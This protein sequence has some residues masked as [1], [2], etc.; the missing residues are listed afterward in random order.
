MRSA[1]TSSGLVPTI[2]LHADAQCDH[3]DANG[4][5]DRRKRVWH[6]LAVVQVGVG[7][8][9]GRRA[10]KEDGK[11]VHEVHREDATQ[12]CFSTLHLNTTSGRLTVL[13]G[14]RPRTRSKVALWAEA[15]PCVLAEAPE[16]LTL[17]ECVERAHTDAPVARPRGGHSHGLDHESSGGEARRGDGEL[18]RQR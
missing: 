13:K 4:K 2:G 12:C 10:A 8:Q 18:A 11:V 16:D 3:D 15:P 9:L 14:F 6:H 7:D 5:E 1:R 17:L